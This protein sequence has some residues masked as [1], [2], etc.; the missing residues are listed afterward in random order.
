MTDGALR[1]TPRYGA[2]L[3]DLDGTLVAS[4]RAIGRHTRLWAERNGLDVGRVMEV[5]HGLRDQDFIPRL[6]PRARVGAELRW[7][8]ELSCRDTEDVT[9]VPGAAGLTG[10]LPGRSWAVVTSAARQVALCR[11][12]AAS[13]PRPPLLICAE[14]VAEGKPSPEGYLRAAG[15]LGVKPHDCL[16]FED[17]AAGLLAARSAGMAAVAVG[18]GRDV[19]HGTPVTDLREVRIR[20]TS[21]G[22]L[23]V[24]SPELAPVPVPPPAPRARRGP[25]PVARE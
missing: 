24:T 21:A 12:A 16:V 4:H 2:A 7:L 23:E 3:F 10:A 15:A 25:R 17:S 18:G 8:H 19:P 9:A 14:E 6:V 22:E 20:V 13:L 5:S 11:L 1:S